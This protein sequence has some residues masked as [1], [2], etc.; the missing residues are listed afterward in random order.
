MAFIDQIAYIMESVLPC[1][2]PT[3]NGSNTC[4]TDRGGLLPGC[5]HH[6]S[7]IMSRTSAEAGGSTNRLET[8]W[9]RLKK[10]CEF[11]KNQVAYLGHVVDAEGLHPTQDKVKVLQTA[12]KPSNVTELN[13]YLGLLCY[14]M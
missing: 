1:N 4:W 3:E 2:I 5:C 11:L 9:V 14:Y 12:P 7:Q 10:N 6:Q 8:T 13:S